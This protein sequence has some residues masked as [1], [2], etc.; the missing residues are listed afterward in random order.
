MKPNIVLLSMVISFII[1]IFATLFVMLGAPSGLYSRT[2]I[3]IT[4]CERSLPR[5]KHCKII[6]V[7]DEE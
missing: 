7:I 2:Q 6:A 4:E 5:D 3:A 1:G